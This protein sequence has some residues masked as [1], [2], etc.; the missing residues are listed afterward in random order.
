MSAKPTQS[1][2]KGVSQTQQRKWTDYAYIACIMLSFGSSFFA[3][4]SIAP[5]TDVLEKEFHT[6]SSGVG[7]LASAYY[8]SYVVCL[9]PIGFVLEVFS[10]EVLIIVSTFI[11]C[12][13]SLVFGVAPNMGAAIVARL[14]LG[15]G[16]CPLF[17][18]GISFAGQRFGNKNV[19]TWSGIVAFWG[20]L[21]GMLSTSIIAL[22][23]SEMN[24]WRPIFYGLSAF[25]LL[26]TF[27]LAFLFIYEQM[28]RNT[29]NTETNTE[30]SEKVSLSLRRSASINVCFFS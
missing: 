25:Q 2:S 9:M 11:M 10:C 15:I 12:I 6:T 1:A 17:V 22:I 18:S 29:R 21:S 13:G 4:V 20:I 7:V 24:V 26:L 14:I 5:I 28:I 19:S 3:R 23:Y 30:S 27:V 8:I 16:S